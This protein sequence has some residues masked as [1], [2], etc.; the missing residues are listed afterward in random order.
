M[1]H[2]ENP[3]FSPLSETPFD[4]HPTIGT[5]ITLARQ[6]LGRDMLFGLGVSSMTINTFHNNAFFNTAMTLEVLTDHKIED[7]AQILGITGEG[8]VL[9]TH[10]PTTA[11]LG[12]KFNLTELVD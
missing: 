8:I 10:P 2:H 7:L 6:G 11:S 3:Q 12:L 4:G 9:W 5:A 1:P